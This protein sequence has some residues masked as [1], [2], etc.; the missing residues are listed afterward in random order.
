M[1]KTTYSAA[2]IAALVFA[3]APSSRAGQFVSTV[4]AWDSNDS[5][6]FNSTYP[7]TTYQADGTFT[8]TIPAGLT[9]AGITITGSFGNGDSGTTALSDYYLGFAGNEEA[10]EVAACD[11]PTANCYSG[12]EGP[13]TWT[14]TLTP[15][16]IATLAS[17]ITAGSI[18]F[19][20]TW[21]ADPP[22]Q[23]IADLLAPNGY[24]AQYVY[25]GAATLDINTTP[26]PATCLFCI[27]GLAGLVALKRFRKS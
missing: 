8:F 17:A 21:D 9:I 12:Q 22:A 11:D 26:E 6:D 15:A 4:P 3:F 20:Y 16:Q 7:P 2:A 14:A 10:V 25:A 13:Y 23:P 24:D 27:S 5:Y 1:T 18:D 19:G